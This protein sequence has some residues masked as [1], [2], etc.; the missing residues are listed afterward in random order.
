MAVRTV[1]L[2]PSFILA[3]SGHAFALA[4]PSMLLIIGSHTNPFRF[5]CSKSDMRTRQ[6]SRMRPMARYKSLGQAMAEM[7]NSQQAAFTV[8]TVRVDWS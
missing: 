6:D 5:H 8:Q 7:L 4:F 1:S 3:V 2:S